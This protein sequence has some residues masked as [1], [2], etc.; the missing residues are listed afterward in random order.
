MQKLN[1]EKRI[2][3]MQKLEM[4]SGICFLEIQLKNDLADMIIEI[5]EIEENSGL[6]LENENI[7]TEYLLLKSYLKKED[8]PDNQRNQIIEQLKIYT[9][10]YKINNER[11]VSNFY[12]HEEK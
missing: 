5:T 4:M 2:E 8:I 12:T 7:L 3:F 6:M 9:S 11:L 1:Y 10:N